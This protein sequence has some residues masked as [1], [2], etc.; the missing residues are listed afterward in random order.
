MEN[1]VQS[2]FLPLPT[3]YPSVKGLLGLV[4]FFHIWRCNSIHNFLGNFV[5]EVLGFIDK[6][7]E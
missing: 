7:L 1:H 2:Y 3:A 6:Q 4:I 5:H